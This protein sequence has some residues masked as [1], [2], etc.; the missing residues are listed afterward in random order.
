MNT[1]ADS[2][3]RWLA[4]RHA[5]WAELAAW[6]GDRRDRP[7]RSCAELS[8]IATAYAGLVA[9]VGLAR[10]VLASDA[11]LTRRLEALLGI[12]TASL[13]REPAR[14]RDRLVRLLGP[15]I[16]ACSRR[17]AGPIATSVTLFSLAAASGWWLI[18]RHPELIG[19]FASEEMIEG[20]QA[21]Q[22]WTDSLLTLIPPSLLAFGIMTNNIVVALMAFTLGAF[23]GLGTLYIL[24]LNGFMLGATFAFTARY[25]LADELFSFVLAHGVVELSVVCLSAAAGI[26]LGEALARPGQRSRVEG[27]QVA[28]GEAGQ[29]LAVCL[30]FLVGAGLIEGYV[31]PDERYPLLSRAV[32]GA[33][34]ELLLVATLAGAWGAHARRAD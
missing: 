19:L 33:S 9:D 8:A 20:V 22:L 25:E 30:P 18:A 17:L 5:R 3:A 10:S 34:Y 14:L 13:Y 15:D 26:R 28:V 27:F 21:G 7:L 6:V 24:G 11:A 29:L 31:S 12:A 23:Y 2:L 1:G 32:I 4:G 16:R